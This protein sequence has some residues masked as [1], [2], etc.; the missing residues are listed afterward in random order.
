MCLEEGSCSLYCC[1]GCGRVANDVVRIEKPDY[2]RIRSDWDRR[3]KRHYDSWEMNAFLVRHEWE[4]EPFSD[5]PGGLD[6]L[7]VPICAIEDRTYEECP[8]TDRCK[9]HSLY[10]KAYEDLDRYEV[11][12]GGQLVKP[13]KVTRANDVGCLQWAIG[14]PMLFLLL[15]GYV[16]GIAVAGVMLLDQHRGIV[17]IVSTAIL[18]IVR[19]TVMGRVR[20]RTHVILDWLVETG[21]MVSVGYAICLAYNAVFDTPPVAEIEMGDYT[22][23]LFMLLMLPLSIWNVWRIRRQGSS[24]HT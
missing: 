20:F 3:L 11:W 15:A 18:W 5:S 13:A 8:N 6:F 2:D 17:V 24:G 19:R 9:F 21:L 23:V 16:M 10:R 12:D 1:E 7:G 22:W 14:I 4:A